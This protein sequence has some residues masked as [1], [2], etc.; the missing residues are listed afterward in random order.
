MKICKVFHSRATPEKINSLT[1]SVAEFLQDWIQDSDLIYDFRLVLSEAC[2]NVMLHAYGPEARGELEVHIQIDPRKKIC[3]EVRD[4]GP[5]FDGPEETVCSDPQD[6]FGRG[7]F[8]I[9]RLVD[10]FGYQHNQGQNTLSMERRIEESAWK[11]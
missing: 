4:H 8:I 5:P 7:L 2:T 11:G 3:M 6:E 1:R 10:S 9:S